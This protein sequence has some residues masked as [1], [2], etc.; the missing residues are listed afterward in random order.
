MKCSSAFGHDRVL[1]DHHCRCR[2]LKHVVVEQVFSRTDA[3]LSSNG[4]FN[5]GLQ[6]NHEHLIGPRKTH[7]PI[8]KHLFEGVLPQNFR[9]RSVWLI[10]CVVS[11]DTE[12]I[13]VFD[14]RIVACLSLF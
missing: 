7:N 9:N 3:I 5:F 1:V 4:C 10:T 6:H 13:V 8:R 2:K 12:R 11:N 14:L